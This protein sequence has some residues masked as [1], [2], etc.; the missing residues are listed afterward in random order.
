MTTTQISVASE[1]VVLF[2][3]TQSIWQV[4]DILILF[5]DTVAIDGLLP[6]TRC[7]VMGC[8][9]ASHYERLRQSSTVHHIT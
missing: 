3:N 7:D 1:T 6:S 4:T 8:D 2:N 9:L 5:L